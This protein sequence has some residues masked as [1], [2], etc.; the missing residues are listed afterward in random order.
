M[1]DLSSGTTTGNHISVATQDPRSVHSE[2]LVRARYW[3]GV[4]RRGYTWPSTNAACDDSVIVA[5]VHDVVVG[6]CI[7]D[8]VFYPLAEL[9]NIEVLPAYR[10]RGVGSA[11]VAEAVRRA[12][13]MGFLAIHAQESKEDR[14]AQ[15][16]YTQHGFLPATQGEML[17]I[18]RFLNLP[19][20]THF[21]YEHPFALFASRA[22]ETPRTHLLR[23]QD[24]VSEDH[25]SITLTGGSCQFD[26]G[27]L[28]P[29]VSGLSVRSGA[30]DLEAEF[31][32]QPT[33][34]EEFS[35]SLAI[36]NRG[37]EPLV[38][39]CRVG[40]NYGFAV[41]SDHPG[42]QE[43]EL[44]PHADLEFALSIG[45]EPDFPQDVVGVCAYPSV[46]VT[47]DVLLGDYTFWLCA[48]VSVRSAGTTD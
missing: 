13:Q 25:V 8:A 43:F 44:A 29:A 41:R 20:L 40:L 31:R 10:G 14:R 19:A 5:R 18:W 24:P 34:Q 46:P 47:V 28:G 45:R 17:R 16:L 3:P 15:R 12:A 35:L 6:R 9:E 23:W 42:G 38:G 1:R 21:L 11:L 39:G 22:A 2:E 37:A 7:L 26:S 36:A 30:V 33:S 32:G 4:A 48:Q 27:G